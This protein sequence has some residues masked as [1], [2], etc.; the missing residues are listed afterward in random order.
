MARQ[1]VKVILTGDGSDELFGGYEHYQ[2]Q[3]LTRRPFVSFFG[4]TLRPMAKKIPPAAKKKGLWN[5]VRRFSQ[6][7]E[8]H[9]SLR[10]L[11]WMMFLTTADKSGLY[12]PELQQELDGIELLS[13]KVPFRSVFGH[14]SSYDETNAELFIDLK[15]YLPDDILV[16]VDRMS[17]A[18]SLEARVPFLDHRLVE[19]VFALPGLLKV[20][21]LKTKWC[22]KKTMA[23]ILPEK[24]ILRSKEGFSIPMKIWLRIELKDLLLDTLSEER[25][26]RE[27]LFQYAAVKKMIDAHLK[28]KENHSHTLWSLIVF[29]A[30]RDRFL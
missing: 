10:H 12:S 29:E 6:G 9:P 4:K 18:A 28:G 20:K 26:N 24:T 7:F 30:W 2:A 17:M 19:F 21:G 14:L 22:L 16:K 3:S 23:G 25:I 1:Q 15:T 11:R 5:K 8:H 13:E 27:G